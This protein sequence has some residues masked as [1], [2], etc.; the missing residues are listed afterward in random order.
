MCFLSKVL[1]NKVIDIFFIHQILICASLIMNMIEY[2]NGWILFYWLMYPGTAVLKVQLQTFMLD[3][4]CISIIKGW[5]V[6]TLGIF[7]LCT[8][9]NKNG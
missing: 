8:C 5:T 6:N 7:E 3:K 2:F 4:P 9:L 1:N